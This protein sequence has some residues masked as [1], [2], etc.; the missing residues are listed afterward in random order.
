ME[1]NKYL[2]REK[3]VSYFYEKEINEQYK[4]FEIFDGKEV[5][6]GVK[7]ENTKIPQEQ[8]CRMTPLFQNMTDEYGQDKER[9]ITLKDNRI[10]LHGKL[11]DS[12]V[13]CRFTNDS[14]IDSPLVEINDFG[15]KDVT[16]TMYHGNAL[17]K[18]FDGNLPRCYFFDYEKFAPCSN[19]FDGVYEKGFFIKSFIVNGRLRM[20]LGKLTYCP[21]E[22]KMPTYDINRQEYVLF[23]VN[24]DGTINE[25]KMNDYFKKDSKY[26]GFDKDIYNYLNRDDLGSILFDLKVYAFSVLTILNKDVK[27]MEKARRR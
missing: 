16:M 25:E 13:L 22:V 14:S 27:Y 20:F 23:P 15:G 1:E 9:V 26:I 4:M 18:Y 17:I 7:E 3:G 2:F 5:K 24:Q 12:E 8:Q 11:N 19:V 21:V 6:W 10:I